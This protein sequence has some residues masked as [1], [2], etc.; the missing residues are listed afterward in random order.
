MKRSPRKGKII[1][2]AA[3]PLPDGSRRIYTS[4][5]LNWYSEIPRKWKADCDALLA[6]M[7]AVLNYGGYIEA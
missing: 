5:S 4:T 2:K 6:W 7:K 1:V 3:L